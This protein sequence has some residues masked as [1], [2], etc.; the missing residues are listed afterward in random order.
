MLPSRKF[1]RALSALSAVFALMMMASAAL[2]ADPGIPYPSTSPL[3]DQHP[4]SVLFFNFYTSNATLPNLQNSR[5]SITNTSTTSPTIVHLFFIDGATC[6]PSNRFMCLT[7]NQT[8]SFLASD[9]DPGTTGFLMALAVDS[10]GCPVSHNFL[11]GSVFVKTEIGHQASLEAEGF[12]ALYDGSAPGCNSQTTTLTILFDG[13]STGNTPSYDRLPR[14][15][16]ATRV[17]SVANGND[18]RVVVNRVGGS[19]LGSITPIGNLFGLLFDDLENPHSFGRS[20]VP[21][22]L[23]LRV[24]EDFPKTTPRVEILI[25]AG[26]IGWFK[27]WQPNVDAGL[28]GSILNYNTNATAAPNAF[29][30]GHNL[31]KLTLSS[32]N[33]LT[34]PVFPPGC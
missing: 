25:P 34:V 32:S 17:P 11:V 3:S 8:T 23:Y 13:N 33:T 6:T 30:G 2:A 24:A 27:F 14:V 1:T 12:S 22:Q 19:L 26:R 20:D 9:Q 18:T 5:F 16:A 28:L 31:H 29:V 4:G 21:C 7:P 10:Q 15:L